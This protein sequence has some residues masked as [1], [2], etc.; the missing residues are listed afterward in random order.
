M[1]CGR[2]G[3]GLDDHYVHHRF[4]ERLPPRGL[5]VYCDGIDAG[6]AYSTCVCGGFVGDDARARAIRAVVAAQWAAFLATASLLE[7]AGR[8]VDDACWARQAYGLDDLTCAADIVD[9]VA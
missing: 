1:N 5:I 4:G 3:H 9:G 2:C 7:A 8:T 6:R